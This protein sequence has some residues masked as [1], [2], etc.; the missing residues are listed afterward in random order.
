MT[1]V[2]SESWL[3]L[4]ICEKIKLYFW[5][6]DFKPSCVDIS[7]QVTF[8]ALKD[9]WERAMEQRKKSFSVISNMKHENIRQWWN[10]KAI[11]LIPPTPKKLN[12]YHPKGSM[13]EKRVCS[14]DGIWTPD[15]M[16]VKHTHVHQPHSFLH[17][18]LSWLFVCFIFWVLTTSTTR[19]HAC[20]ARHLKH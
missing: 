4:K 19:W 10:D 5:S 11:V 3:T 2:D 8:L 13:L 15:K 12:I 17:H 9:V 20:I 14:G 1:N 18:H 16:N 6:V 7:L